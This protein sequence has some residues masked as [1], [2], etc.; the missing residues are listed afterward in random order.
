M[1]RRCGAVAMLA[2]VC[3]GAAAGQDARQVPERRLTFDVAS[4]RLS[5]PNAVNG[6]IKPLPEGHG[7]TARNIPLKLIFSLMYRVPMRQISGGPEWFNDRY[8]IEARADGTYSVDDLHTMFQNLLADRFN[9]RFHKEVKEGNVYALTIDPAG[10]KMKPN[11]TP[12]DYNIPVN[13]SG[14]GDYTGKRVPMPYLCWFLGQQVQRDER[15][16]IDETGLKGNYDFR[17]HFLPELPPEIPRD[18]LP[19]EVLERPSLFDA[20]REQLGL[21]LVAQKG[22]V[23][24]YVIDRLERPSAN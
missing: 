15:P 14:M 17:L 11:D 13:P 23:E 4:I 5:D 19:A 7:Y 24:R 1:L 8:D 9:L 18:N 10:L 21:K 22:P 3:G 12:Q 20:L 6:T 16:V 2:V